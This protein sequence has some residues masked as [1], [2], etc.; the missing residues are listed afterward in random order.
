MFE[1]IQFRQLNDN[2]ALQ[3]H[4]VACLGLLHFTFFVV[5]VQGQPFQEVDFGKL[6]R[7]WF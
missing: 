6:I 5:C 1:L 4:V 2:V 3:Q 7:E